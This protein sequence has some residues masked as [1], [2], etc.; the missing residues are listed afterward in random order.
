MLLCP[1][2]PDPR[3][4]NSDL[5]IL[6]ERPGGA[7]WTRWSSEDLMAANAGELLEIMRLRRKMQEDGVT[8]PPDDIKAAT[9]S[10]VD[11][12]SC[13]DGSESIDVVISGEKASYVRA[14]NGEVLAEIHADFSTAPRFTWGESVIVVESGRYGSVCDITGTPDGFAY[15]VEFADGSNELILET[16]LDSDDER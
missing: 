13:I 16:K 1:V 5:P 14:T 8:N 10:L 9:R 15:T 12:L 6:I 2:R 7:V 11:K 4:C 3:Y